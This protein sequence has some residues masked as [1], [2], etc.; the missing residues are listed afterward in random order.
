MSSQD[1]NP[2]PVFLTTTKILLPGTWEGSGSV[3]G[4][5]S[6]YRRGAEAMLEDTGKLLLAAGRDEG[7]AG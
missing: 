3:I 7:K 5:T 6:S 1:L 4:R 2:E